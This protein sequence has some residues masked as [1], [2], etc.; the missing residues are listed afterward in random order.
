LNSLVPAL[1]LAAALLA[2]ALCC[3]VLGWRAAALC[4]A[5]LP[6]L[7]AALYYFYCLRRLKAL[8]AGGLEE[9]AAFVFGP[10]LWL[11]GALQHR[12]E[13][14]P[15]L[16]DGLAGPLRAAAEIGRGQGG[17]L[18][19]LCRA[20]APDALVLSLDL[21]GGLYGGEVPVLNRAPW[22]PRLLRA[23][24]GP[25]QRLELIDGDSRAPASVK[26]FEAALAG[27][28]LD[29]LFIDGDHTYEGVKADYELYSRFVRPGGVIAFHD[30]QPGYEA[31]GV[32]VSRFWREY[33]LPG[34][35]REYI[36]D[37]AQLS[38]GIGAIRL[39]A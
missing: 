15:F 8:A 38:C 25:R 5:A 37:P 9:T 28:K 20:A 11:L 2:A 18:A 22:R 30:I 36:A 24:A 21:P 1:K 12:S 17:T 35:R 16:R 34:E 33:P 27:R 13:I 4:L 26:R 7:L 14:L 23:L 19:L 10:G 31:A 6:A 39:P 3:A 32:E 29:L